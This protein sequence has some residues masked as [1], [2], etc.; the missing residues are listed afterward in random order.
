VSASRRRLWRWRRS[1]SM[2]SP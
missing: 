1:R 2:S